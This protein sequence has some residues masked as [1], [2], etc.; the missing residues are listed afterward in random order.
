M[1]NDEQRKLSHRRPVVVVVVVGSNV[2][3]G[4][5]V[6]PVLLKISIGLLRQE[7]T[8]LSWMIKVNDLLCTEKM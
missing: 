6:V 5:V 4:V 2:V 7:Y 8:A 3:V 1:T